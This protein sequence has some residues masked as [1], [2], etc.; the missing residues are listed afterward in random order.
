[1]GFF[2]SFFGKKAAEAAFLSALSGRERLSVANLSPMA[3]RA[4]AMEKAGKS[5]ELQGVDRTILDFLRRLSVDELGSLEKSVK[6]LIRADELSEADR[7]KE[8]ATAYREAFEHNPYNDLAMMSYGCALANSG[9]VKEGIRWVEKALQVNPDN[10]RARRNLAG[11]R[12]LADG[13]S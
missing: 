10:D 6:A 12:S 4:I 1:M 11:M 5:I 2:N 13:A 8:A 3:Y 7:M 9:E